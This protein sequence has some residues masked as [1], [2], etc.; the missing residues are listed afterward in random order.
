MGWAWRPVLVTVVLVVSVEVFAHVAG[1][2]PSWLAVTAVC[3][4]SVGVRLL[5]QSVSEQP[6]RRVGDLVKRASGVKAIP[7]GGWYQGGD[8]MRDA[9]RRWD[10]RL[11]WGATSPQRYEH[12]VIPHL[13]EVADEWL[14]QHHG[15]TRATHPDRARA[16]LGEQVWAALDPPAG[17]SPN[18]VQLSMAL[19][20]FDKP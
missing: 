9:I 4:G 5:V 2:A 14:R 15:I 7:P 12:S 17:T 19:R 20:R 8:G 16:I 13:G 6:W 10:R 18:V 11:E 1:F 3:A